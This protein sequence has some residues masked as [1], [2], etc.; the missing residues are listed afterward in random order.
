MVPRR[1]PGPTAGWSLGIRALGL[2]S[3]RAVRRFISEGS[4][5]SDSRRVNP[6]PVQYFSARPAREPSATAFRSGIHVP[7]SARYRA[8]PTTSAARSPRQVAKLCSYGLQETGEL[9][10]GFELG[11]RIEFLERRGEGVRQAPQCAWFEL[12]VNRPEVEIV[13][14]PRQ[15]LRGV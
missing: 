8:P 5:V 13:D 14:L 4:G 15:V 9:R 3:R 2:E 12:R 1:N 11:Y 7:F 6:S 10:G